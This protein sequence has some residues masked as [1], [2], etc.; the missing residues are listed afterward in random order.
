MDFNS[1]RECLKDSC[2]SCDRFMKDI[3][4]LF[5]ARP[6][7]IEHS[8]TRSELNNLNIKGKTQAKIL[9]IFKPEGIYVQCEGTGA[10]R[11]PHGGK[12]PRPSA[13]VPLRLPN[14]SASYHVE[15]GQ[16]GCIG[17]HHIQK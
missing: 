14:P 12:W 9:N 16:A 3:G 4:R 1:A 8:Y 7:R 10:N 2:G 17:R 6:Y 13:A 11:T 5:C 15:R